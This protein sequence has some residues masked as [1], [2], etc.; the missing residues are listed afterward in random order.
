MM[1]LHAICEQARNVQCS[2]G[3]PPG[4]PCICE[5]GH[6]HLSRIAR[7]RRADLITG[8]DFASVIADADVFTG[9]STVTDPGSA[10]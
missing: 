2:C 8:E 4:C 6:Y 7:T 9:A 3:A 1:T 10:A 5:A